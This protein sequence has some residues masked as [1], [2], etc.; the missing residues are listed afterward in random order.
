MEKPLDIR[1]REK[2][3]FL[4]CSHVNCE[5]ATRFCARF[6]GEKVKARVLVDISVRHGGQNNQ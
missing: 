3:S 4:Y 6:W 2:A 5:E 1:L